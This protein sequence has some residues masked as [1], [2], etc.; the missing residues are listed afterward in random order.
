MR[1]TIVTQMAELFQN[2]LCAIIG[3]LHNTN[4]SFLNGLTAKSFA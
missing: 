4:F 3:L 1:I 2:P